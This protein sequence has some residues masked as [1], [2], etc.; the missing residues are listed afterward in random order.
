[1][2]KAAGH[3]KY[4][5][6]KQKLHVDKSKWEKNSTVILTTFY[7]LTWMRGWRC[8]V[9]APSLFVG[10]SSADRDALGE[11]YMAKIS[12]ERAENPW[13][14][15]PLN[16]TEN[17]SRNWSLKQLVFN[18]SIFCAMFRSATHRWVKMPQ[19]IYSAIF[20]KLFKKPLTPLPFEHLVDF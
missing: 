6:I 4:E 9:L 5:Y 13:R 16:C 3:D 18:G 10:L 7:I 14:D 2:Q 20:W 15:K 11:D 1:M 17:F 12:W 8:K 19:N